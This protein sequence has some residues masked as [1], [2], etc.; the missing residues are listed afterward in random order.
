MSRHLRKFG[1]RTCFNCTHYDPIWGPRDHEGF[2][3]QFEE[4]VDSEIFAAR[5]CEAFDL[6]AK[7]NSE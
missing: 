5:H 4:P 7:R 2:C 1:S 6:I 3:H